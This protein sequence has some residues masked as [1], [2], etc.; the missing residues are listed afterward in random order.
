MDPLLLGIVIVAFVFAGITV[1]K[2]LSKIIMFGVW[3]VILLVLAV[4][5]FGDRIG[6][7]HGWH[8]RSHAEMPYH[9]HRR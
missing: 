8:S 4:Y 5:V 1:M 9:G 2:I 6:F 3:G 7:H